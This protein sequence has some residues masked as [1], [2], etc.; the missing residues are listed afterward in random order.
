MYTVHYAASS[1]FVFVLFRR[2]SSAPNK[3]SLTHDEAITMIK[4]YRHGLK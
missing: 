1:F 4:T 3:D 2:F